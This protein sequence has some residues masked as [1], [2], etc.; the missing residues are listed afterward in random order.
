[1]AAAGRLILRA[2]DT[3]LALVPAW[4]GGLTTLGAA[5]AA[6]LGYPA[7]FPAFLGISGLVLGLG[8]GLT[9]LIW[10]GD[11]LAREVAEID[12]Q[13][14]RAAVTR[15]RDG[16]L[17]DAL[18][19]AKAG[20]DPIGEQRVRR[21]GHALGRI[22][23]LPGDADEAMPLELSDKVRALW[24]GCL[25]GAGR[26][27]TLAVAERRMATREGRDRL[28]AARQALLGEVDAGLDRLD[29]ALDRLHA[30]SLTRDAT[31]PAIADVRDELDRGL[32]VAR[33]VERR[34]ADLD[35]AGRVRA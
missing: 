12:R 20:R 29:A 30:A 21:L 11:T 33:A 6:A 1:M 15:D 9:R 31:G 5:G 13:G 25:A 3:P 34:M 19:E 8:T 10:R 35:A 7:A 24:D 17:A 23:T 26:L 32:D 4:L 2:F 22:E 18:R 14:R 27:T 16:R 28:T